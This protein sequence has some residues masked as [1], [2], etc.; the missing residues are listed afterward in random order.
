MTQDTLKKSQSDLPIDCYKS[1][2]ILFQSLNLPSHFKFSI[3]IW[4]SKVING[5]WTPQKNISRLC[6]GSHSKTQAQRF[7]S[8]FRYWSPIHVSSLCTLRFLI[9]LND[10]LITYWSYKPS[11]YW[12]FQNLHKNETV[13]PAWRGFDFEIWLFLYVLGLMYSNVRYKSLC[14][15]VLVH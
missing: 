8:I 11:N 12:N 13:L 14:D 3:Q 4:E 15:S 5:G 9:F 7:F 2:F 1:H 10:F 6:Q